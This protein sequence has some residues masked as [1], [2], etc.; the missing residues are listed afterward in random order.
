MDLAP[1]FRP[2]RIGLCGS[3]RAPAA[4][5]EEVCRRIGR[6]V[7]A[8]DGLVLVTGG[9]RGRIDGRRAADW[10]GATAA[11]EALP[12]GHEALRI[13]TLEN[14]DPRTG[15]RVFVR[16]RLESPRARTQEGRRISFVRD[17]DALVAVGGGSGTAQEMALATELGV[18]VLALPMCGGEAAQHWRAHREAWLAWIGADAGEAAAWETGDADSAEA[19]LR[20]F[21]DRLPR[22]CFV[23]MPFGPRHG[24][25]YDLVIAPAVAA[26]GD[27]VLRLDR[28]GQPGDVALQIRRNVGACD[29]A[30]VVL[31]GLRL[32]VLYELGLAHGAGKP[33]ILLN[34]ARSAR[35]ARIPFDI[36]GQQRLEYEEPDPSARARLQAVIAGLRRAA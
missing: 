30:V 16:G 19:M 12:P 14:P 29:Y 28:V 36:A 18:P 15:T 23:A 32:N 3:F 33:A 5:A 17:L 10:Y 6:G 7:A 22:R 34:R 31:D 13:V 9:T 4:L 26:E 11:A 1:V 2:R 27:Q 35:I 25:L 20:R 21:L 8:R 24:P